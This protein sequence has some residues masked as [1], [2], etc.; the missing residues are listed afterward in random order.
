MP[1]AY[2]WIDAVKDITVLLGAWVAIVSVDTW[3]RAFIVTRRLELAQEALG[4]GAELPDTPN[5]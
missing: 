1:D 4:G 2:S 5:A 3:R